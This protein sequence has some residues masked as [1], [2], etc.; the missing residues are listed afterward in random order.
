M[1]KDYEEFS[2]GLINQ[3]VVV[4]AF[5]CRFGFYPEKIKFIKETPYNDGVR[6]LITYKNGPLTSENVFSV[7]ND[8]EINQ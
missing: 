7:Y 8:H 6:V 1:K 2:C 3:D 5:Y 4:K